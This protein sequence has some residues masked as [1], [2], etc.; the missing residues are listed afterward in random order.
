M[1]SKDVTLTLSVRSVKGLT[2]CVVVVKQNKEDITTHRELHGQ[3][4]K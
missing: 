3:K 2:Q 1:H 4:N